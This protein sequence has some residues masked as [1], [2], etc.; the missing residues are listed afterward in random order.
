M[1]DENI[2]Q[3][4][5]GS[6]DSKNAATSAPSTRD[7]FV[8]QA[9]LTVI[10]V[11]RKVMPYGLVSKYVFRQSVVSFYFVDVWVLFHL[12]LAIAVWVTLPLT[13]SIYLGWV[14]IAYGAV[15]VFELVVYN[16]DVMFGDPVTAKPYKLRSLRRSL[17]LALCNYAEV[18]FWFAAFYR[19]FAPDFGTKDL[20][21]TAT[22]SFYLSILTMATYGD[23]QPT[24]TCTRWIVS[25][26][27]AI[28]LFL[29]L[30]VLARFI[31]VLPRPQSMDP[32]EK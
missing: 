9:I 8:V 27:L 13:V 20:V 10:G 6:D 19:I 31:S 11:A 15:R 23:I 7:S 28:S 5:P 3:H 1:T 29:T 12:L 18:L 4:K 30:G 25:A 26:H 21:A 2:K 14:L 17:L 22:G 16:L 24:T 32:N